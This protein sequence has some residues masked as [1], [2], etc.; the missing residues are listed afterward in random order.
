MAKSS[1]GH[2]SRLSYYYITRNR[3]FL[4]NRWLSLPWKILFHLYYIP[5]R[6][7]IQS[8]GFLNGKK[9]IVSAVFRGLSDGYS[10]I[11]WK[12]RRHAGHPLPEKIK[13]D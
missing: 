10:G 11:N 8:P 9:E 7:L 13:N 12:W 4:A 6:L 1:G 3:I 2:G 5:S